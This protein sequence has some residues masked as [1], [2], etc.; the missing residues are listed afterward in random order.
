MVDFIKKQ[1]AIDYIILGFDN[2]D[3]LKEI[4]NFYKKKNRVIQKNFKINNPKFLDPREWK[5]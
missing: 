1:K 4:Y 2:T 3:Q 5:I